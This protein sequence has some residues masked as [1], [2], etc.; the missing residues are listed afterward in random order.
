MQKDTKRQILYLSRS[1]IDSLSLSY[2]DITNCVAKSFVCRGQGQTEMPP[3]WGIFP[4]DSSLIHA[5]PASVKGDVNAA[6]LKWVSMFGHNQAKGLPSVQGLIVLNDI[7][8]G[9]PLSVMDCGLITE[10]RTAAAGIVTIR[11]LI[12]KDA[13]SMA[14][15]GTGRVG[16]QHLL[17]AFEILPQLTH[18]YVYDAYKPS[19]E[20]LKKLLSTLPGPIP[21]VTFC[22][23]IEE[24]IRPADVIVSAITM[25]KEVKPAINPT[26]LK[27]EVLIVAQ[28]YDASFPPECFAG[29][30][31]F[32]VD[33]RDQYQ[34]T[35]KTGMHFVGFPSEPIADMGEVMA[36]RYHL[37]SGAKRRAAILQGIATHDIVTAKTVFEKA[38]ASDKGIWLDM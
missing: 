36:Q 31:E 10:K 37:K 28:D 3:K 14:I 6:G 15:I 12:Q 2:T 22:S 17:A 24:A 38:K 8:T 35:Q 9:T 23:T 20:S 1:H 29:A 19:L 4:Q 21:E 30:D 32:F 7:E 34:A 25:T 16:T 26:W 18:F 5:M 27:P 13:K 11:E 33:D